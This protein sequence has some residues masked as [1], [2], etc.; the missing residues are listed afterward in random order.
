MGRAGRRT[1]DH[2]WQA[3][4]AQDGGEENQDSPLLVI[5]DPAGFHNY[6][7]ELS[8]EIKLGKW[9]LQRGCSRSKVTGWEGPQGGGNLFPENSYEGFFTP[10]LHSKAKGEGED[11]H[12]GLRVGWDPSFTHPRAAMGDTEA[13]P[14]EPHCQGTGEW[15][16]TER[17][18]E[19]EKKKPCVV[20]K[21]QAG[22]EW[23]WGCGAVPRVWSPLSAPTEPVPYSI[24][25][26]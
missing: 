13:A 12:C 25:S 24:S 6:S 2:T 5:S 26:T 9:F 22:T 16:F 11:Q 21:N 23:S 14:G 20:W 19:I 17:E 7:H 15:H 3:Q 18:R 10:S 1:Q 4:C 8:N